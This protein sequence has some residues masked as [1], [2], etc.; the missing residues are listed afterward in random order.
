MNQTHLKRGE[1]NIE[2][3]KE[4]KAKRGGKNGGIQ[5]EACLRVWREYLS[6]SSYS[7]EGRT[8]KRGGEREV[9]GEEWEWMEVEKGDAHSGMQHTNTCRCSNRRLLCSQE[10][11]H[12]ATD[13]RQ[14]STS[15]ISI[16]L[17]QWINS[18][19]EPLMTLAWTQTGAL[20]Y[21]P[22]CIYHLLKTS[23]CSKSCSMQNTRGKSQLP[24]TAVN[25]SDY[26]PEWAYCTLQYS[27]YIC[28]WLRTH[29]KMCGGKHSEWQCF[30]EQSRTIQPWCWRK[31]WKHAGLQAHFLGTL[32]WMSTHPNPNK[33]PLQS[34]R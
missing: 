6:L 13:S 3:K 17:C 19:C 34:L 4:W 14:I 32:T 7:D 9:K 11:P 33:T 18:D 27:P 1:D 29:N 15:D 26:I 5:T 10:S 31:S 16:T 28:H 20:L 8:S 2:D 25:T 30:E 24:M 23:H 12:R 22:A 21:V